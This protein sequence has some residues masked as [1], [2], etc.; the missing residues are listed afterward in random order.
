MVDCSMHA[1]QRRGKH[2]QLGK[3]CFRIYSHMQ[4]HRY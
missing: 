3:H 2:D 4:N 1:V